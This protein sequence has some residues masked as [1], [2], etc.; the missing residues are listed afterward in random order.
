VFETVLRTH[1]DA[2]FLDVI[3]FNY[4]RCLYRLDKKT[5]ARKQFDQAVNEFRESLALEPEYATAQY[6]LGLALW[7]GGKPD[8]AVQTFRDGVRRWPAKISGAR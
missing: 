5:E 6:G 8:D 2:K 1:P 7:A 4:G 3:L